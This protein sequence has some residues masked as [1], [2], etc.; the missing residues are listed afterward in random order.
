MCNS[1]LIK[2]CSQPLLL[3]FKPLFSPIVFLEIM[4]LEIGLYNGGIGL[5]IGLYNGGIGL[6]SR[7]IVL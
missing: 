7:G 6:Y 2:A 1:H 4:Q 5:Y 3:A